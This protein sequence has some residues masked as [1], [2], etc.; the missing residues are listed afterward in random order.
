LGIGD[1]GFGPSH[2]QQSPIPKLFEAF[3]KYKLH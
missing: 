1:W 3:L 2:N